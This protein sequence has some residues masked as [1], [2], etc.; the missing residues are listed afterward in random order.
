MGDPRHGV[1]YGMEITVPDVSK[2]QAG[3]DA[4]HTVTLDSRALDDFGETRVSKI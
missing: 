2:G 3:R 1:L 4:A